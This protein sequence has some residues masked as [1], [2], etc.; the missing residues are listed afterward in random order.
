MSDFVHL[1]LHTEY[2][3]LDGAC[4]IDRLAET[5]KANGHTAVAITDHGNMF[6]AVKFYKAC[7]AQGI[8]PI[9]GCE[10]YVAGS[11]RFEKSTRREDAYHHLV[12]LAKNETGY[13]N[14][15]YMVSAAYTE[16]FYVKPRIDLE[17]LASHS[18]GLVALSACLAGFIPRRI[19]MGDYEGAREHA[20]KMKSI[21]GEDYYLEL[22]DHGIAEQESVNKALIRLSVETGI[23]LVA[24]NDVH[25]LKKADS[26]TQAILM[27]IQTNN[28][29]TDG[30]PFGFETDEFY[31][32]STEEMCALFGHVPGAIENT[33]RIAE[34]CNFDFNFGQTFLP[35]YPIPDGKTAEEYLRRLTEEGFRSRLSRGEVVFTE[36]HP[37]ETYRERLEYELSVIHEMGYDDYFLIVWDFI[38]F[39]RSRDI[40]VGPGRGSGAGSLVAYCLEI[41]D[42]DSIR[43]DL[44]FERFLNRERVSMPD[45]D[46]DFCYERRDEV[47]AY[48]KEKYG[49][50]HVAQIVTFGT[51]AARAAVRDTG[52]ALGAA[53]SEVDAI[54]KLISKDPYASLSDSLKK[55]KELRQLYEVSPSARKLLDVSMD[56]E[57]MPRHC[58]THAA[59]V[60]ITDRPLTDYVPLSS[61]NGLVV[62]EYDMETVSELGLLKFDFLALRYL[63][64]SAYAERQVKLSDADFDLAKIPLDDKKTYQLI[65]KGATN[66]VFQLESG[67]MKQTLINLRPEGIEDVIAAIALYRPGPMDAIPTYIERR[68][69]PDLISYSIPCLKPILDVTYG[70]IV[71]QEQVMQIFRAVAG[72]SFGRAD[73][74][75]RAMA[76]KK[77]DVL[78]KERAQFLAGAEQNGYSRDAAEQ[79]FNDMLSFASYAFNKAHAVAYGILSYRT[80]Y[81]KA[82]YPREYYAALITSVL[83]SVDKMAEYIAECGKESIK[84]L[85]PDINKSYSDFRVEGKH[86]RFGLKAMKNVGERFSAHI[87]AERERGGDF[88]SFE[89]FLERMPD[90]DINKRSIESLVKSGAFDSTGLRRSQ[91]VTVYESMVED[92]I[93][94]AKNK[95]DGQL[96]LFS[97]MD[98]TYVQPTKKQEYPDMPEFT[99]KTLLRM[100]REFTGIY[101][102]GHILDGYS[103]E[104]ARSRSISIGKI[105]E[106][107]EVNGETVYSF[108]DGGKATVVG[109]IT[110]KV[111]KNTKSGDTMAFLTLEDKTG[112]MEII[113]FPKVLLRHEDLLVCDSV[114]EVVGTV[115]LK[116]DEKPKLLIQTVRGIKEDG[117][118]PSSPEIKQ[119]LP[120]EQEHSSEAPPVPAAPAMANSTV[121]PATV[122][123]VVRIVGSNARKLYVKVPSM[124]GPIFRRVEALL[125]IFEG[126]DSVIFYDQENGK[127]IKANY[128]HVAATDFLVDQ[129]QKILGVGTVAVK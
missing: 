115:S 18:D 32:K 11:S 14:L 96:D 68:H 22:Q 57:G 17:L 80:A 28:V 102:S 83:G 103:Q 67:G 100:E 7:K 65:G 72:Y 64:V 56:I 34:K 110:A 20:L 54:A 26:E 9:I 36:Q 33:V 78:E 46:T 49:Q 112:E 21:F 128:L 122:K 41:T 10:V 35:K 52:R 69:H 105:L 124:Q 106:A 89:D 121:S 81:L 63:T 12:L 58:S 38:H 59:G 5:A 60:V 31:Y 30:K 40:P 93:S 104:I 113:A 90:G 3:L 61:N 84:I 108:P 51:L 45:I 94:A 91:I 109:I 120:A 19:V 55:N 23:P 129:L 76:K 118:A 27:C 127:Y 88:R 111:G 99:H 119:T 116:E 15:I 62:T 37:E 95:V 8:K 98:S 125:G 92:R 117:A 101:F 42:V 74:V 1:H 126:S 13:R 114:V 25:Y 39:A 87:I 82:N 107:D 44:I 6:G 43:Y 75:R 4:R 97:M 85:P 123:P 48:V 73:I 71:Y 24:T 79:L 29:I 86:I 2:S 47:I 77:A 66:G 50:D 53:Y 70:C 16:G